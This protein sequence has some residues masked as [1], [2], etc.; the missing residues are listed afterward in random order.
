MMII[1]YSR[2]LYIMKYQIDH[3]WDFWDNFF[4]IFYNSP[5]Y[6]LSIKHN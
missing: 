3:F 1:L 6:E 2:C 4:N 5:S